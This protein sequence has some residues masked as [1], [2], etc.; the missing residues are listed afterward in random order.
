MQFKV[1]LLTVFASLALASPNLAVRNQEPEI[2]PRREIVPP[3]GADCCT[4]NIPGRCNP[5]C[6]P[7]GR[8]PQL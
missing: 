5:Q 6:C 1:L 2:V 3:S 4:T 8:C 7:G